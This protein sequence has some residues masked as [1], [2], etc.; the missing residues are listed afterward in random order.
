MCQGSSH[1]GATQTTDTSIGFSNRALTV[2]TEN[3]PGYESLQIQRN[4]NEELRHPI[5]QIGD[6]SGSIR[7]GYVDITEYPITLPRPSVRVISRAVSMATEDESGCTLPHNQ[8]EGYV[9]ITD[10]SPV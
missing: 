7:D 10:Y 5:A 1:D 2:E 6:G 8:H 9:G 3:E 4:D